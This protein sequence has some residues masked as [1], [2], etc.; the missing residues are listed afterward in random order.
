MYR[1]SFAKTFSTLLCYKVRA[2]KLIHDTNSMLFSQPR[3]CL[4][5][6]LSCVWNSAIM[7][8]KLFNANST[9]FLFSEAVAQNCSVKKVFLEISQNSQEN[10][11]ARVSFFDKVA[12]FR[13]ATLLKKRS[14]AGV[15]L[16][17]LWNFWEHLFLQNTSGGC[18]C[19]CLSVSL[20][21][22][23]CFTSRYLPPPL[24]Y[25]E[26]LF[27]FSILYSGA[28]FYKKKKRKEKNYYRKS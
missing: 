24:L 14:G 19:F 6:P 9:V 7:L 5:F 10:T 8:Y 3:F 16:W 28:L 13:P 18:F 21:L 22:P 1:C 17:V 15:F 27:L 23:I 11:R 20:L 2:Q 4:T 12:G 26:V 25:S